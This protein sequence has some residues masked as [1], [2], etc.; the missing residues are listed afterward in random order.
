MFTTITI[1]HAVIIVL[2]VELFGLID[3]A[4]IVR[5]T[6]HH[7]IIVD[8]EY[9]GHIYL[10]RAESK[11]LRYWKIS[12]VSGLGFNTYS[13]ARDYAKRCVNYR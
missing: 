7:E 11:K 8:G 12:C 1:F 3:M 6:P 10:C 5:N 4:V 2:I 9:K 13:E